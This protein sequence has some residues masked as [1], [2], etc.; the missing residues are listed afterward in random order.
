LSEAAALPVPPAHPHGAGFETDAPL[1][2]AQYAPTPGL[3]RLADLLRRPDAPSPFAVGLLAPA[4]AGKTSA[5]N[6]LGHA[7]AAP[8]VRLSA[9]DLAAEPEIGLAGALYA[10]LSPRCGE[11]TRAA[12]QESVHVGADASAVARTAQERL[13]QLNRRLSDEKQALAQAEA[14]RAALPETLLYDTPGARVDIFARKIRAAFEPRLRRF[15]FSGDSLANFKDLTRDMAE[16]G[17]PFDRIVASL[18]G[19]YDFP[20]QTRLLFWALLALGANWGAKWL[21]INKAA[22]LAAL[23]GANAAGA[24][25][26]EFL[27]KNLDWLPTGAQILGVIGLLCLGLNFFRATRFMQPLIQAAGLL[28]KDIAAKKQELDNALAHQARSVDLVGAEA[29]VAARTASEAERRAAGSAKHTPVFLE[30][31][32]LAHKRAVARGFLHCLSDMVAHGAAADAPPRLIV[33]VDGFEA[34]PAG[35]FERLAVLLARPGFIILYALD[36]HGAEAGSLARRL[37]LPLNLEAS[38]PTSFASFDA[39]LSPLEERLLG[40]LEPLAGPTPRARKKLRNF[41]RFLRPTPETA[42]ETAQNL[43]PALAFVLAAELGATE[44][45]LRALAGALRQSGGELAMPDAPRLA[46][47]LATAN[48]IAGPLTAATARRA[49]ELAGNLSLA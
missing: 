48:S 26:A 9:V 30:Q 15:G 1:A 43:G 32:E 4:G 28:D 3:R 6:W 25:S 27:Q 7:L 40:A 31:D 19:L 35:L 22:W 37:Q 47:F 45:E 8:F 49:A 23:A 36:S 38:E 41:Y 12:A 29:A 17:G 18:R 16:I 33:A 2:A 42:Q 10:A 20:G 14:R 46:E 11:L 44:G 39:P 13:D 21:V 24:Q 5:L 34:A